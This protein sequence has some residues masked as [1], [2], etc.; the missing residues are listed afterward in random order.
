M[1]DTAA[2]LAKA[3]ISRDALE[4]SIPRNL[5]AG[6]SS[7][8]DKCRMNVLHVPHEHGVLTLEELEMTSL[9][10]DGLLQ[11]YWAGRWTVEAVTRAF[12][13]RAAIGQ[14]LVGVKTRRGA[15][16][17]WYVSC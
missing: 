12:L 8:P 10:I 1:A 7:L 11:S 14:Q 4:R 3:Q 6:V 17:V 13:K 9:D 5:A 16:A 15:R 2:W